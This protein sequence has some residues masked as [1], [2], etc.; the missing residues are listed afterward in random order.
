MLSGL[1]LAACLNAPSAL[2]VAAASLERIRHALFHKP[3]P[4]YLKHPPQYFPPEPSFPLQR[5]L[6]SMSAPAKSG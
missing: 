1:V 6:D 5:E 2:E 3:T 4:H